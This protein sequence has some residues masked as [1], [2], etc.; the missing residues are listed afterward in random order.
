MRSHLEEKA[1]VEGELDLA[2]VTGAS[3]LAG[4]YMLAHLLEQGGW[5]IVAVSRRKPRISGDYRHI[6]VDLLDL[7]DCRTKL[8]PLTNISHLFYLAITER[9]EAG[10][11]MSANSNMFF[12][13]GQDR[14]GRF[15]R[16][17]AC[18]S[19]P[20]HQ[21][22]RKSPWSL[23]DPNEEDHPRHMPPNFYYDQQDFLEQLQ[24]GKR[25]DVVGRASAR[26]LW[27]LDWRS[28]EPDPGYRSL[29]ERLEGVGAAAQLSGKARCLYRTVPMHG[30][31]PAGKGGRMDGNRATM[32]Q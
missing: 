1:D 7:A 29:R 12:N 6:A 16:A 8:G 5:D 19:L 28:D 18:P 26:G 2:L 9:S 4:G 31:R 10:E 32:R 27:I 13:L 21:V 30:R 25:C 11:T 17:R 3:G 20:R 24:K 22:V 14:R 15:T 23:Q